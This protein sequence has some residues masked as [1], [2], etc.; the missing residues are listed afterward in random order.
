MYC[1]SLFDA[2]YSICVNVWATNIYF[3][4]INKKTLKSI[5]YRIYIYRVI[6]EPLCTWHLYCNHQVYR[7]FLITLYGHYN[8]ASLQQCPSAAVC[9]SSV[10]Q[11]TPRILR[12]LLSQQ[13]VIFSILSQFNSLHALISF[14]THWSVIL[15]STPRSSTWSVS[16]TFSQQSPYTHFSIT[17]HKSHAPVTQYFIW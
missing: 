16:I 17:P 10:N 15:P 1:C 3:T 2:S 5:N 8:V 13:P 12:H 14:N 4:F 6:K 9:S 11:Q 7:D